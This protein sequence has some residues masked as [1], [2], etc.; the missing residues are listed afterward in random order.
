MDFPSNKKANYASRVQASQTVSKNESNFIHM[1][2]PG[3][4]GPR[5]PK[6]ELGPPGPKGEKGEPGKPGKNGI[7]GKNGI[8]G[9]DG[10]SF[11]SSSGQQPGWAAYYNTSDNNVRLGA[12]KGEDGWVSMFIDSNSFESVEEYLPKGIPS[13]YN[14]NSRRINLKPLNLGTRVEVFY[15]FQIQTFGSNTEL[16]IRSLFPNSKTEVVSYIGNLKYQYVY[17]MCVSQSIFLHKEQ[18]RISGILPQ[19]RADLDCLASMKSIHI[20]VS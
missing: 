7:D 9:K 11:F 20:Y 3:P 17:E 10:K 19:L 16:S 2:V 4:E 18:D 6:G 1:P 15:T 14:L 5:G 12:E 13:L 8:N